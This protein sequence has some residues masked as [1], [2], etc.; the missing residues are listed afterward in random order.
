ML[1]LI[2]PADAPNPP[3]GAHLNTS[4][5]KVNHSHNTFHVLQELYL[6]TSHVKVN[7]EYGF[8]FIGQ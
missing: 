2:P 1:K 8:R 5:V 6:N 3:V 4:H 7:L